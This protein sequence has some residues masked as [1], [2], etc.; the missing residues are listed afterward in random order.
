IFL[1]LKLMFDYQFATAQTIPAAGVNGWRAKLEALLPA[2]ETIQAH[3]LL[4][5][6]MIAGLF[7]LRG[8][9]TYAGTILVARSGSKA[10]KELRERIFGQMLQQ[11]P[12]FFQLHPVG[13]LM[14]RVLGD[15]N[16]VQSLASG[17]TS[18]MLKQ[19][20][21][22]LIMAVFIIMTDWH[23]ALAITLFFPC[24]FLPIR[25]FSKSVRRQGHKA[26]SSQD[27]LLQRL[28]E[29]LSNMRVVKAFARED[30]E[31]RRFKTLSHGL[32][33]LSMKVV[34]LQGL[35]S[36]VMET[37]GGIML[38]CLALYGAMGIRAG[39]MTGGG[40]L[41]TLLAIYQLYDPIRI[42]TRTY[43]DLQL[44]TVA[45]ERI[46]GLLDTRPTIVAPP[47]PKAVPAVPDLLCFEGV[48]FSYGKG[49]VLKS[50]D[51]AVRRGETVAL[52]GGSGGGK[53]SLV[54]LVPRFYDPTA[55]RV[56]LDGIDV[57]EF[58]PRELRQRIGIVTQETLLFQDSVHD[59]IAYG[60]QASREAVIA[61]ARKAFAHE[62]I[63]EMP[64]G[65][66]SIMAETGSTLSGGQRQRI[67]IA[68]ALLQDPPILILDE[69]TSALDTESE[70]AVQAALESLMRD[71]TTLV[72]A[73]RLSTIQRATR[74]CALKHGR[75]VEQGSHDE[76]LA[77]GGEY[78]R[79]YAMQF[80]SA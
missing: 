20:S 51:L 18:E 21:M 16:A 78:A 13:E 77:K 52:V 53:T 36:P 14:N 15:V 38:A 25:Y 66:D 54:N 46:F 2:R 11:D 40:F 49:D 27:S 74:I 80:Q 58:D 24:V 3:V 30:Y 60:T 61:A 23:F 57:R 10:V 39:T 33:R 56:T 43:G 65:Y 6:C 69:A 19:T 75:I 17:L 41:I 48:C 12:G 68:R 22:A 79:L 35:S 47:E 76:L 45:L 5:P 67:A 55:G 28:K 72:I 73:H 26:Q 62:F 59:N 32:Y 29:V 8:L 63:L 34:R 42:L 7:F 37:V 50:I 70:R 4:I 44:S 71:R 9:F 1:S 64:K 31:D